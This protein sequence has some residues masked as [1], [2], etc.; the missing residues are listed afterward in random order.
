VTNQ[1][2]V[3]EVAQGIAAPVL[4]RLLAGLGHDVVK[5]EPVGGDYL[6]SRPPFDRAGS[7]TFGEVN[8]A[9]RGVVRADAAVDDALLRALAAADILVVDG[10]VSIGGL[11]VTELRVRFPQLVVVAVTT[12]GLDHGSDLNEGDSLLAEAA[13]GLATVIGEPGQ[14]PL[15]LGAEQAA[16]SAAFVALFGAMLAV[17]RR[18]RT[19][20][21]DLVD[22]ALRDVAAYTDWKSDV[23]CAFT[24][25][26][27]VRTGGTAGRWRIV[28]ARDGY[29]GVIFEAHQWDAFVDLVG[30]EQLRDP[31]LA[32]DEVRRREPQTWW[33]VVEEWAARQ[34]A[35]AAY[36]AAQRRGLPF[37]YAVSVADILRSQQYHARG[38]MPRPGSGA[39]PAMPGAPFG[40]SPLPWLSAPAPELGR[41]QADLTVLW[42]DQVTAAPALGTPT[43]ASAAGPLAGVTVLDLGTITAGAAVG[44]LLADYGATVIKVESPDRPDA[45]RQWVVDVEAPAGPQEPLVSPM[46][47][48]NNAGK[49]AVSLDLKSP[50]G[51]AAFRDL[52]AEADVLIE[53]FS[54]GVTQRLGID[55]AALHSVNPRL[56]YLSLSSQGQIGP[57]SAFRSYGSTLDLLSGLA[58]VTG[59]E[60]GTPL[61]SSVAV[62]YPD[63]LASM[64]GAAIVA[65]C[66]ATGVTGVHLDLAQR[67]VVSWT[68]SDLVRDYQLTGRLQGPTGNARPGRSPHDTYRCTGQDSWIALS[69]R[70]DAQRAA[71]ARLVGLEFT[72]HDLGAWVAN[73]DMVDKAIGA[74]AERST[75][76]ECAV[77]LA[78]LGV[79]AAEVTTAATR[80]ADPAL[81]RRRVF[82]TSG[83]RRLKGFPLVMAGYAPPV[84]TMAPAL[85]QHNADILDRL[86]RTR[87][88]K[89]E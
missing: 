27:P 52:A 22:V 14:R 46:F 6:R 40:A 2:R 12:Y 42:A 69:C 54:V 1:L 23:R 84:P 15:S 43:P 35:A 5:C 88:R 16:F 21:G 68:L 10:P 13:G 60:S 75:A 49:L 55:Y 78:A 58:S 28:P 44:R 47:D 33:P 18:A 81:Q 8:R 83:D 7:V 51:L 26:A 59:Y 87:S 29:L 31:A 71:L 76:S 57:E 73:S 37:G 34:T 53:N 24:G 25:D 4:G 11:G 45:F 74:W 63:Q 50:A 89:E 61:W 41:D 36:A 32:S 86:G 19:G 38:F 67:E 65:C 64:F 72:N 70:T 56:V 79:P 20:A 82:L 48:S 66:V 80:T 30:D 77:R 3:L 39:G 85:G 9:K 17:R 62:N